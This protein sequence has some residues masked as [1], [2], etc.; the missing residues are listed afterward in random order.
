MN[1]PPAARRF[2]PHWLLTL[3]AIALFATTLKLSFW[4]FSRAAEK[5]ALEQAAVAMKNSAALTL[6][7]FSGG[8]VSVFQRAAVIGEYLPETEFLLDNRVHQGRIG[9]QVITPLALSGGGGVAVNRGW[10]SGGGRRDTLPAIAPPPPGLVT[11]R[12]VFYHDNTG[13]FVLSDQPERGNVRQNLFLTDVAADVRLS[14]MPLVLHR[15]T[16][17]DLAAVAVPTNF[18]SSRSTAYAWQWLTFATLTVLFYLLLGFKNTAAPPP[19]R[20][21]K[22]NKERVA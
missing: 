4:Q 15:E 2:R 3:A 9:Y 17:G 19:N 20:P 8:A 18:K 11:V 12:G 13:A 1:P 5:G 16:G 22:T 7:A 21:N 14:L 6:R 10:V